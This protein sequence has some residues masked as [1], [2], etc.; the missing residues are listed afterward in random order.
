MVVSCS[1]A[2]PGAEGVTSD[3]RALAECEN[4]AACVTAP[5]DLP[6]VSWDPSDEQA[7][8]AGIPSGCSI[9]PKCGDPTTCEPFVHNTGSVASYRLRALNV[10]APAIFASTFVSANDVQNQIEL[11]QSAGATC[12]ENGTGT[13]N[14]LISIDRARN[15][16]TTGGAPFSADPFELGYCYAHTEIDGVEIE[17]VTMTA[18][19]AGDTFATTRA[20]SP[21]NLPVFFSQTDFAQVVILPIREASFH[22]VTLS[23]GGDCIGAVNNGSLQPG[24]CVDGDPSGPASCSRWRTAGAMGGYIRLAD[25]DKIQLGGL[26]ESLCAL[27]TGASTEEGQCSAAAL[28]SGDYCSL[29]HS[30]GGCGDSVWTA[31]TF[32][33][34]A[35]NIHDGRGVP[36]CN[37][38]GG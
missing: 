15:L 36:V 27:L 1:S 7:C 33:A 24:S 10:T 19:F 17:P 25:A 28:T 3:E 6:R 21:L 14:W 5:G 20:T 30:A 26:G 32:A 12:G 37:G 34:S 22:D 13:F 31:A 29:T 2:S 16:V 9:S 4:G 8:G 35:V 38:K 18:S 23:D 11:P